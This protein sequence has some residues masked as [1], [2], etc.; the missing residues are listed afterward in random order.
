MRCLCGA[1]NCRGFIGGTG[2]GLL[3]AG[4]VEDP[5]DCSA[6]PEPIMVEER[7]AASDPLLLAVLEAEVGLA[8]HAWD[9][10]V[11][12][13]C[14]GPFLHRCATGKAGMQLRQWSMLARLCAHKMPPECMH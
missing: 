3:R 12:R 2:E 13:R 10:N 5:A 9:A 1:R 14:A 7:E 4:A 11:R 8:A 6:D